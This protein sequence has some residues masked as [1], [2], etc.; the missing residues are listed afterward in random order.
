MCV[1][2]ITVR[3][4]LTG[5]SLV[6]LPPTIAIEPNLLLTEGIPMLQDSDDHLHYLKDS[7]PCCVRG[8]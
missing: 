6:E 1:P 2:V 5:H 8:I 4:K 3:Y 7:G